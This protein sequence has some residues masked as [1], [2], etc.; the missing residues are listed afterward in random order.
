MAT[1]QS[2]RLISFLLVSVNKRQ[3][4]RQRAQK[5][6]VWSLERANIATATKQKQ[7]KQEKSDRAQSANARR[8]MKKGWDVLMGTVASRLCVCVDP[9][10]PPSSGG[11]R[12]AGSWPS[13]VTSA[14][15]QRAL[16]TG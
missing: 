9:L 1:L 8:G 12:T 14:N 15:G 4:E 5:T 3:T 13:G 2:C 16:L 10:W 7:D 11:E 6:D